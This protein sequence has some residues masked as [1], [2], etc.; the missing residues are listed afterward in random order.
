M[1]VDATGGNPIW[2]MRKW[3]G[4]PTNVFIMDRTHPYQPLNIKPGGPRESPFS[5]YLKYPD[6]RP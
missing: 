5:I 3:F 6:T 1:V 4:T 2:E